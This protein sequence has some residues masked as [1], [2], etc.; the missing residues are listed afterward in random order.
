MSLEPEERWHES[1]R[2]TGK[3]GIAQAKPM[4]RSPHINRWKQEPT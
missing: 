1:Q 2:Y 3:G 4:L